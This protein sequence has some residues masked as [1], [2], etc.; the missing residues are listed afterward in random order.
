MFLPPPF[1]AYQGDG[2]EA[3]YPSLE[4]S[5]F[6]TPPPW[7]EAASFFS[8]SSAAASASSSAAKKLMCSVAGRSSRPSSCRRL[9]ARSR[10]APRRSSLEVR[11]H[12]GT[13]VRDYSFNSTLEWGVDV[14]GI[15]LTY[16]VDVVCGGGESEKAKKR[17]SE[18][19]VVDQTVKCVC[20]CVTVLTRSSPEPLKT[21][22]ERRVLLLLRALFIQCHLGPLLLPVHV[23]ALLR[24][25]VEPTMTSSSL[26]HFVFSTP[27]QRRGAVLSFFFFPFGV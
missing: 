19:V 2:A 16:A 25:N 18:R 17:K 4:L 22:V 5:S 13:R 8:F 11:S 12:G 24:E 20:V 7:D 21:G 1:C 14:R 27:T 15:G 26:A 6:V 23:P 3:P 9:E 10:S